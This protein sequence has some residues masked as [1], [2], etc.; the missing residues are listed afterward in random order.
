MISNIPAIIR[1]LEDVM[2]DTE[3]QYSEDPGNDD[4]INKDE[5]SEE[6]EEA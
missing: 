3:R 5:S 2:S 6:G 4:E 1:S